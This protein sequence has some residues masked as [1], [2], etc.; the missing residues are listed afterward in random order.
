MESEMNKYPQFQFYEHVRVTT[1]VS[2]KAHLGGENGVVLGRTETEG[3]DG[4]LYAVAL[5]AT[6]ETWSFFENELQSLGKT[7]NREDL[8]DGSSVRVSVD[9]HGRGSVTDKDK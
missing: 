5:N 4:W 6:R 3:K 1:P 8:Y 2:G 7:S 9:E